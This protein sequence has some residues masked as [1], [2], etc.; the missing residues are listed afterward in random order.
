MV[1]VQCKGI[2]S[3]LM[4]LSANSGLYPAIL[5]KGTCPKLR[6]NDRLNEVNVKIGKNYQHKT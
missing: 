5:G 3:I 6:K 1:D 4:V 2:Q